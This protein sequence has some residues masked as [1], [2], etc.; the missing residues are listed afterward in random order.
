MKGKLVFLLVLATITTAGQE[1]TDPVLEFYVRRASE[2]M[3]QSDSLLDSAEYEFTLR[4]NHYQFSSSEGYTLT[5]SSSHRMHFT[6]RHLDSAR[7]LFDDDG[8]PPDWQDA[9]DNVFNQ[10]YHFN[11]FPNDTGGIYL[12]IGFD[13]DSTSDPRPI[14]LAVIDRDAYYLHWLYLSY[15]SRPGHDRLSRRYHLVNYEGIVIADSVVEIGSRKGIFFGEPY[16][17][18]SL[19]SDF[20]LSR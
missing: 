11:F 13:T 3:S 19:I 5:D 12:S 15:S 7:S 14:G 17:Q 2:V 1:G 10:D 16:R 8:S 18:E 4:R 6:G 20:R 9:I